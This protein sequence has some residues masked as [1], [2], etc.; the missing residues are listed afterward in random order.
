M[1]R[2][3]PLS[4]E[5]I[6]ANYL[7]GG[8][9]IIALSPAVIETLNVQRE[10]LEAATDR[11]IAGTIVAVESTEELDASAIP[12]ATKVAIAGAEEDAA[13]G[14]LLSAVLA[15]YPGA[16]VPK[17][18]GPE[19]IE[20]IE[21]RYPEA[22]ALPKPTVLWQIFAYVIVTIAEL[23]I[24]VVG[25]ELAFTTAPRSMKGFI[26]GCFLLTVFCGNQLNS[27]LVLF[28]PKLP[29]WIF[30]ALMSLMMVPVTFA[31]LFIARRFNQAVAR[32][33]A[34]E[35]EQSS[36]EAADTAV[37]GRTPPGD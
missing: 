32:Q 21:A 13:S 35:A 22:I 33:L 11:A 37:E 4:P 16:V 25:L 14:E 18:G 1:S 19:L 36:T 9:S 26:T 10:R 20:A 31:F 17:V 29:A 2:N 23:C 5:G 30:F 3:S 28:Y 12:D 15:R 24:S 34:S 27:V 6:Y 7:A 8:Y